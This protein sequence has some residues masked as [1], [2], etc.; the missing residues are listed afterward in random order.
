MKDFHKSSG[1]INTFKDQFFQVTEHLSDGFLEQSKEVTM[2]AGK[3]NLSV[4]YIILGFR[5]QIPICES[6]F[7]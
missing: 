4:C 5:L 1:T 2:Q 6:I 3:H 7:F